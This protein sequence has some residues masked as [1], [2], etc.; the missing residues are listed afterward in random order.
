MQVSIET[1]GPDDLDM[2]A[3]VLRACLNAE[4]HMSM[5]LCIH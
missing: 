4:L 1:A 2:T 5:Q 3:N